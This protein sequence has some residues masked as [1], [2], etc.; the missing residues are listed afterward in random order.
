MVHLVPISSRNLLA[1]IAEKIYWYQFSFLKWGLV[2]PSRP[3][4]F[5]GR[6]AFLKAFDKRFLFFPPGEWRQAYSPG[7]EKGDLMAFQKA[8][9]LLRRLF[10]P[11]W[12]GEDTPASPGGNG[13]LSSGTRE[14]PTAASGGFHP[15]P[16][17]QTEALPPFFQNSK[18][19]LIL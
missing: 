16:R 14:N 9:V 19:V 3:P 4:F 15:G 6:R 7:G 5:K 17:A 2:N 1:R 8:K 10:L 18:L 13:L 11:G 12:G